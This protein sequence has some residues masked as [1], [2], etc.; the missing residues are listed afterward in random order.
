MHNLLHF[1]S[2]RA[3]SHAQYEIRVYAEVILEEVVKRWVPATYQA[4]MDYVQGAA[5]LSAGGLAVVRRLVAGEAVD[6]ASS[7]LSSREWRELMALLGRD[8]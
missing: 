8:G 6:Q 7:G 2:L 3:D 4:F 5:A 1:L